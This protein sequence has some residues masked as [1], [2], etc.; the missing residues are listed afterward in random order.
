MASLY[1]DMLVAKL[2]L[3]GI[4][5][6]MM[7]DDT[8]CGFMP[9][10]LEE[11]KDEARINPNVYYVNKYGLIGFKEYGYSVFDGV[12][13]ISAN[14]LPKTLKFNNGTVEIGALCFA[15]NM[16]HNVILPKTIEKLD[17]GC[18]Y[19]CKKLTG[20]VIPSDL[21]NPD[22]LDIS[23]TAFD[24]TEALKNLLK[25]TGSFVYNGQFIRFA[26]GISTVKLSKGIKSL[27]ES[28][29]RNR[30]KLDTVDLSELDI[31]EL[32]DGTFRSCKNLYDLRL[33]DTITSIG[34]ECFLNCRNLPIIKFDNIKNI[35]DQAFANCDMFTG[36]LELPEGIE[37]IG[38][39][40]FYG[41]KLKS[42]KIP[43]SV[44]EIYSNTFYGADKNLEICI[45]KDTK[46]L[47][48][49][50]YDIFETESKRNYYRE[51]DYY[52]YNYSTSSSI[53][54]EIE[55]GTEVNFFEISSD[56]QITD[57]EVY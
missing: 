4:N 26:S 40:A 52:D 56:D 37:T 21:E 39:F 47:Y 15:R 41:S 34:D 12:D 19:G 16:I 7:I 23:G 44:K 49:R 43:R 6:F 17:G 48:K 57:I 1:T 42:I 20:L 25:K 10:G 51:Y 32:R 53:K 55:D 13:N 28:C 8:F 35:G 45:P 24:G 36:E 33:P 2:K 22:K 30:S 46:I 18:F 9:T 14:T 29:F 3:I 5:N 38:E 11:N 27:S 54:L 50:G 31:T